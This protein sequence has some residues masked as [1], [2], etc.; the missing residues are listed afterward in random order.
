MLGSWFELIPSLK[1]GL[2]ASEKIK[3]GKRVILLGRVLIARILKMGNEC[4]K[5]GE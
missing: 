3:K 4:L 5:R 2:T 1:G